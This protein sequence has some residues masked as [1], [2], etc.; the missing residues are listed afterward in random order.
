M[1]NQVQLRGKVSRSGPLR[2]TAAGT[3]LREILVAVP[4]EGPEG[5]TIGYFAV[6]LYGGIAE[7]SQS[8]CRVG[9]N[10][11]IQGRLWMRSY[12][13][14]QDKRIEECKVVANQIQNDGR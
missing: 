11:R 7:E 1:A 3:P 8:I 6:I 10:V 9:K 14:R 5:K 13:N 2:Y 12:R 4:Q